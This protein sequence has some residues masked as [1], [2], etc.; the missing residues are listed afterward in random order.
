MRKP[1]EDSSWKDLNKMRFICTC[2]IVE[3]GQSQIL[4][5]N[6]KLKFSGGCGMENVCPLM[7]AKTRTPYSHSAVHLI[8]AQNFF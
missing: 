3:S 7:M 5:K 4:E 1:E 6:R 8:G 2:F